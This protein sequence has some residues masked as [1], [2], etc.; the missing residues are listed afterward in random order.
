MAAQAVSAPLVML[1]LSKVP[2][3]HSVR[4]FSPVCLSLR[5]SSQR[6]S[7]HMW[8]SSQSRLKH[9]WAYFGGPRMI[10]GHPSAPCIHAKFRL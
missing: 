3:W 6:V 10:F 8:A 5:R 7:M 4:I 1:E 2:L 9:V